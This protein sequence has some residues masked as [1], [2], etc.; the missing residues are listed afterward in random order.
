MS[1]NGNLSRIPAMIGFDPANGN[2][3]NNE[4]GLA[5]SIWHKRGVFGRL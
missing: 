2:I 3:A 4:R 5:Q 1:E